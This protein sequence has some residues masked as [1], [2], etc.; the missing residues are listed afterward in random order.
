MEQPVTNRSERHERVGDDDDDKLIVFPFVI[1]PTDWVTPTVRYRAGNLAL[2][3]SRMLC[4]P[5]PPPSGD[6]YHQL[7]LFFAA[8][9]TV[10][11][12]RMN[13]R[14]PR[15]SAPLSVRSA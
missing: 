9:A 10:G 7:A 5:P 14:R 11:F 4:A 1:P 15:S 3:A 13:P 8:A 6:L 2:S 12:D